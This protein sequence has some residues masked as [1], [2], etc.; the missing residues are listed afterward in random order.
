MDDH[1]APPSPYDD[2][3]H[4][5]QSLPSMET[6]NR[7][8]SRRFRRDEAGPRQQ[9]ANIAESRDLADSVMPP[10][11]EE[12]SSVISKRDR[13][14]NLLGLGFERGM[15]TS[16]SHPAEASPSTASVA[17]HPVSSFTPTDER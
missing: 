15:N 9:E 10:H 8:I 11:A 3:Q 2:M 6:L 7:R 4:H 13:T 16:D 17:M 14:P 1:T 5:S 12:S